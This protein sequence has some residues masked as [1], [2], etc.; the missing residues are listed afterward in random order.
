[1]YALQF[2]FAATLRLVS[3]RI[4]DMY[5]PRQHPPVR[6]VIHVENARI[7]FAVLHQNA[8]SHSYLDSQAKLIRLRPK[9]APP[10]LPTSSSSKTGRAGSMYSF[11][12]SY[13]RGGGGNGVEAY[14]LPKGERGLPLVLRRLGKF[15]SMVCHVSFPAYLVSFLWKQ[16]GPEMSRRA[17]RELGD[18]QRPKDYGRCRRILQ[19]DIWGMMLIDRISNLHSGN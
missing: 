16:C 9:M 19:I 11:E 1:M 4:S 3:Y 17:E 13:S 2:R 8:L 7:N 18:M 5:C 14:T 10:L 6:R 12:D 15:K